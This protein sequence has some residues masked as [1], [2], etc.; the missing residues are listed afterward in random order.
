ME[1]IGRK[2]SDTDP[3]IRVGV[4]GTGFMGTVHARA[5]RLAGA[6]LVAVAGSRPDRARAAARE[7]GAERAA[8]SAEELIDSGALVATVDTADSV[9]LRAHVGHGDILLHRLAGSR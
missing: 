4:V 7:L 8:G 5:A 2:S 9:K 3:P 1:D 6:R